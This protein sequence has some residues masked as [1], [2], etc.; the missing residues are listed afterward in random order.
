MLKKQTDVF[1]KINWCLTRKMYF[2][3]KK[4]NVTNIFEKYV[5][6]EQLDVSQYKQRDINSQIR[7]PELAWIITVML[8]FSRIP[9]TSSALWWVDT[10]SAI[11]HTIISESYKLRHLRKDWGGIEIDCHSLL[12]NYTERGYW[13]SLY[14][15]CGVSECEKADCVAW[16][17]R[18]S[19]VK[20]AVRTWGRA[21]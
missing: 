3:S 5:V 21:A 9:L 17:L 13:L 15:G 7:R 14:L 16:S 20:W 18:L 12:L 8:R 19:S 6:N 2:S 10:F 4:V 11:L 1:M